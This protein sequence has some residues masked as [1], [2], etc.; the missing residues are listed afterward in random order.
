MADHSQAVSRRKELLA[1]VD[2]LLGQ[3]EDG[4][5][6]DRVPQ[7]APDQ[8]EEAI[9]SALAGLAKSRELGAAAPLAALEEFVDDLRELHARL[10][11]AR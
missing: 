9:R 1:I 11:S 5:R 8:A 2:D 10:R 7:I 6:S 3:I 4:L